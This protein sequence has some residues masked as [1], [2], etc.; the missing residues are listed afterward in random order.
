MARIQ[1]TQR[2]NPQHL[3]Y[4]PNT[5]LQQA[6]LFPGDEVTIT[7]IRKGTLEVKKQ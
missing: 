2:K 3:I 6:Q 5:I 7:V 4:L 1:S